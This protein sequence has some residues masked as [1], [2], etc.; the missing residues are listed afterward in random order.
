MSQVNAAPV[1]AAAPAGTIIPVADRPDENGQMALHVLLLQRSP[2]LKFH[3]GDWAFPGG[4]VDEQDRALADA[5]DDTASA[6]VAAARE[7]KEEADID[8][9]P[10]DLFYY[11][12]W[13]TPEGFKKRF[14]TWF[15]LCKLPAD[16]PITVDGEEMVD[17]KWIR[18]AEAVIGQTKGETPLPPPT[19]VTLLELEK[20][21]TVAELWDSLGE[22]EPAVFGPKMVRGDGQDNRSITTIYAE[23]AGYVDGDLNRPGARHRLVMTETGWR[24]SK[25]GV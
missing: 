17:H 23:D 9:A 21:H 22:H 25:A 1:V 10:Q 11:S 8:I 20:F 2:A 13:T 19:Y 24:Y 15:F 5:G 16:I 14:A 3:G 6:C 12:H 7:A 18:P 4:R